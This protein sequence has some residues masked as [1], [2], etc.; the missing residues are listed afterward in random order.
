[1]IKYNIVEIRNRELVL[2]SLPTLKK[3][4]ARLKDMYKTDKK[5][6][7]YYGWHYIPQYEIITILDLKEE[8]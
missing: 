4:K 1:M 2:A 3:A 7:K 6:S 5:L 8:M